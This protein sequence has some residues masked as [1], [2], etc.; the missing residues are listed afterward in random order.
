VLKDGWGTLFRFGNSVRGRGG[1][2]GGRGDG[3]E[4]MQL[5]SKIPEISWSI[6][7]CNSSRS[8]SLYSF[9]PAGQLPGGKMH[10]L[11]VAMLDVA[12]QYP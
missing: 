7:P 6:R 5:Q 4:G 10:C 2:G 9:C 12:Q 3:A 1:G 11:L 8:S